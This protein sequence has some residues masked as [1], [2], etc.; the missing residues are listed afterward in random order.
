MSYTIRYTRTTNHITGLGCTTT[1]RGDES[2]GVVG[3]YA[4]N[5]CG[6]LTRSGSVMMTGK[7]FDDLD[8]VMAFTQGSIRKTCRNCLKA[9]AA[10]IEREA[11]HDERVADS[12]AP[13]T[14]EGDYLPPA[15][16][17]EQVPSCH[18]G[19]RYDEKCTTCERLAAGAERE[20]DAAGWDELTQRIVHEID[21][22]AEDIRPRLRW[23]TGT[24]QDAFQITS[25]GE[26]VASWT[27]DVGGYTLDSALKDRGWAVLDDYR[28]VGP[29]EY[30]AAVGRI[31][32]D[33]PAEQADDPTAALA[34]AVLELV[35]QGEREGRRARTAND[36]ERAATDALYGIEKLVR[37]VIDPQPPVE[38]RAELF[39]QH[40]G[41]GYCNG[42]T[43]TLASANGVWRAVGTG[44][45]GC[46][47]NDVLRAWAVHL[48]HEGSV[49]VTVK[50][51]L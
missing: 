30:T 40:V 27:R 3:Y 47:L 49:T 15:E 17:T 24:L 10:E 48:G 5:P 33:V 13:S 20:D 22:P 2:G 14:G 6:V 46:D 23:W 38:V 7:T 11:A 26:L 44:V 25:G 43:V 1:G 41:E 8:E 36:G 31:T 45:A 37:A 4:Q 35:E 16:A 18:H 21:T 39:N 28:Q 19:V 12:M 9:L 42:A 29:R 32:N 34:K 51:P 50:Q